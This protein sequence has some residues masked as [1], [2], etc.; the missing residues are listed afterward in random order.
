VRKVG[1]RSFGYVD[2]IIANL[3]KVLNYNI[4]YKCNTYLLTLNQIESKI[5]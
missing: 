2:L 4:D 1:T 5:K 3:V